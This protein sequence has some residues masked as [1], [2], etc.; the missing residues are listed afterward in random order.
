[1]LCYCITFAWLP[2]SHTRN[3][4][5]TAFWM[6]CAIREYDLLLSDFWMCDDGNGPTT[7]DV[8]DC[9]GHPFHCHVCIHDDERQSIDTR[10]EQHTHDAHRMIRSCPGRRRSRRAKRWR[11][12]VSRTQTQRWSCVC[13]WVGEWPTGVCVEKNQRGKNVGHSGGDRRTHTNMHT[14]SLLRGCA[15]AVLKLIGL[16][17]SLEGVLCKVFSD[18]CCCFDPLVH[19]LAHSQW[20]LWDSIK[21]WVGVLRMSWKGKQGKKFVCLEFGAAAINNTAH[22]IISCSW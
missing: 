2:S 4:K 13:V 8:L 11:N 12:W 20:T 22:S 18:C 3:E 15:L 6:F 9:C 1:M 16:L 7:N 17:Q 21:P 14:N 19:R 5:Y 10:T